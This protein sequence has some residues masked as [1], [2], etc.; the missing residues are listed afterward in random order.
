[1]VSLAKIIE[2]KCPSDTLTAHLCSVAI[3]DSEVDTHP[4][5]TRTSIVHIGVSFMFFYPR[6]NL[7]HPKK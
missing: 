4:L 5:Y 6:M 2:T 3:L 7:M 1:M